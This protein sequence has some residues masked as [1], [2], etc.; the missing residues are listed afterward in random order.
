MEIAEPSHILFGSDFPFSRHRTPAEDV[1]SAIA[2][3]EA[4][5]D[6]DASTRQAIEGKNALGLFPRL[7]KRLNAVRTPSAAP[8]PAP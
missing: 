1:K 7:A 8:R 6:W 2:A 3:F 4:F 5:G